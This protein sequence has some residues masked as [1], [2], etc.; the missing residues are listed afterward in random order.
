[1]TDS[2]N[3]VGHFSS[4]VRIFRTPSLEVESLVVMPINAQR[5][6]IKTLCL[7]V[8]VKNNNNNQQQPATAAAAAA[9]TTTTKR[10]GS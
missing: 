4:S 8:R 3:D 10:F 2:I 1:M 7:K 9:A 5:L 6:L